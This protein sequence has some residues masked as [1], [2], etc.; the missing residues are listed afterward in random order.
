[1]L[2]FRTNCCL[3]SR[4]QRKRV[5]SLVLAQVSLWISLQKDPLEEGFVFFCKEPYENRVFF[6][7]GLT[8]L[9]SSLPFSTWTRS[10]SL[11]VA[12]F[13]VQLFA[14]EPCRRVYIRA[15]HILQRTG[16][17]RKEQGSF[18]KSSTSLSQMSTLCAVGGGLHLLKTNAHSWVE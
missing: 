13:L 7:R 12:L 14:K 17:F 4:H 6:N 3:L 8:I 18:A 16:L 5:R 11:V 9:G 10:L 2:H 1:M 15:P